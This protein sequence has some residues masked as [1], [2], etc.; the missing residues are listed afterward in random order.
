MILCVFGVCWLWWIS[1]VLWLSLQWPVNPVPTVNG[2]LG[3]GIAWQQGNMFFQKQTPTWFWTSLF[4][5][6]VC[7]GIYK[8]TCDSLEALVF[9]IRFSWGSWRW[10]GE[11][12]Y[13][14]ALEWRASKLGVTL[15]GKWVYLAWWDSAFTLVRMPAPPPGSDS[16]ILGPPWR[17]FGEVEEVCLEGICHSG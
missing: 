3:L 10:A 4:F 5:S 6:H 17:L 14:L 7:K 2:Y 8:G 12:A 15:R 16:W 1:L 11:W 13:S 9:W